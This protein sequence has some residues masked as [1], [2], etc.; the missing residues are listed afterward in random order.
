MKHPPNDIDNLLRRSV[1]F[2]LKSGHSTLRVTRAPFARAS[3]WFLWLATLA[4]S[5]K[6]SR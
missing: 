3:A 5:D 4:C 1:E 6:V 2:A